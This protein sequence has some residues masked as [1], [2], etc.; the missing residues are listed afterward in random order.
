MTPHP[1]LHRIA[2]AWALIA[3]VGL[4][5]CGSHGSSAPPPPPPVMHNLQVTV[6]GRGEVDS[7]PAGLACTDAC[8]ANYDADTVVTLTANAG[9]ASVFIGWSGDDDCLDGQVTMSAARNCTANFVPYP[10]LNISAGDGF[11]YAFTFIGGAA[12][13]WGSDVDEALGNGT[14]AAAASAP[15]TTTLPA[16][17]TAMVTSAVAHHGLAV[18][19]VTGRVWAW[20]RNAEGQ[21]GDGSLTARGDAVVMHD[22]NAA[23]VTAATAVA[24]GATHSLVLLG[25]GRVLAAGANDAGQLGDG[26]TISRPLAAPVPGVC[27]AGVPAVAIAAG[28]NFSLALCADGALR[29]WGANAMGQLGDGSLVDRSSPV[30]VGGLAGITVAEIAA[31]GDFALALGSQ[32]DVFAWGSNAKGQLGTDIGVVSQLSTPGR[33]PGF[34][35][36]VFIAAGLEHGMALLADQA[37]FAWGSNAGG[38]IDPTPGAPAVVNFSFHV[39]GLSDIVE[40]AAGADH[41]M[42]V[43]ASGAVWAWGSNATGQLGNG[44]LLPATLPVQVTGLNLLN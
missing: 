23:E 13:D 9:A 31:G 40:I 6:T 11:S 8:N 35:G 7:A 26:T 12:F 24:T 30:T 39:A 37:V 20:G 42:A 36:A 41:S 4:G 18:E 33:V 19:A 21:L 43:D 22:T 17:V 44:N 5:A 2:S 25:D 34:T 16:V 27:A 3:T 15:G 14:G 38:Q 29:A 1:S 28:R 10:N 32:G